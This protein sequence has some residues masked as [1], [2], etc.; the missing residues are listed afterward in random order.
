MIFS[1]VQCK[2]LVPILQC[3]VVSQIKNTFKLQT[4]NFVSVTLLLASNVNYAAQ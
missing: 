3:S 4:Q 2:F 1:A